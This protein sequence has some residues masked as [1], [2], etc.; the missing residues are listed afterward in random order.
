MF[1]SLLLTFSTYAKNPREAQSYISLASFIVVVPAAFSQLIGLTDAGSQNWVNFVPVLN[2]ANNIRNAL[3]GKPDWPGT[4]ITVLVS[5][6]I[7]AVLV[8]IVVKL[9]N[10][11]QV[12]TRV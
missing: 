1:A 12:L 9:F 5:G 3:L 10:R 4:A 11:E 2:A 6:A 7:A 8:S